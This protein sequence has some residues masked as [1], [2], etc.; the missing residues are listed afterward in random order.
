VRSGS[1]GGACP[2]T[3]GRAAEWPGAPA[4][5]QHAAP[6]PDVACMLGLM[7]LDSAAW[8]HAPPRSA[9]ARRRAGTPAMLPCVMRPAPAV[10]RAAGRLACRASLGSTRPCRAVL[11]S[12]DVTHAPPACSHLPWQEHAARCAR[13][14]SRQRQAQPHMA[15]ALLL[16][17]CAPDCRCRHSA[18]PGYRMGGLNQEADRGAAAAGQRFSEVPPPR[19]CCCPLAHPGSQAGPRM[20]PASQLA[21]AGVLMSQLASAG[22][23]CPCRCKPHV[24][25]AST[26][27]PPA[28]ECAHGMALKHI[29][30]RDALTQPPR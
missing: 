2:L 9:L 26:C 13:L 14:A 4:T 17:S 3:L 11:S 5:H 19:A 15:A 10:R 18:R 28:W 7:A 12:T 29:C 30:H 25:I 23:Q 1:A 24:L 6:D 20:R 22:V 8:P 27:P 16:P 21:L